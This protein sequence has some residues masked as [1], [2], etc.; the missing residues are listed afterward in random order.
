MDR[1]PDWNKWGNGSKEMKNE[2]HSVGNV[3]SASLIAFLRSSKSHLRSFVCMAVL[4]CLVQ[5]LL[6]FAR[7]VYSS[8]TEPK[9]QMD[10]SLVVVAVVQYSDWPPLLFGRREEGEGKFAVSSHF[11]VLTPSCHYWLTDLLFVGK[12]GSSRHEREAKNHFCDGSGGIVGKLLLMSIVVSHTFR[13]L[14]KKAR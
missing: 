12:S 8:G 9:L 14:Q 11:L 4:V 13:T 10:D 7:D 6:T 1:Q 5:L 3:I 2:L